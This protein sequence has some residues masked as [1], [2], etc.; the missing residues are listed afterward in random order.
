M[1][2]KKVLIQVILP[3]SDFTGVVMELE[4]VIVGPSGD[5]VMPPG[6]G[7]WRGLLKWHEADQQY[8]LHFGHKS[9]PVPIYMDADDARQ[10][11]IWHEREIK[12]IRDSLAAAQEKQ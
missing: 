8:H 12:S 9:F 6:K 3:L 1:E 11:I 5:A 2:S 10:R 4:D 7:N